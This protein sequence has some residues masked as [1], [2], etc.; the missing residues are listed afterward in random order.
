VIY[1][2]GVCTPEE[3]K[4]CKAEIGDEKYGLWA[5]EKCEKRKAGSIDPWT[6]HLLRLRRLQKAGYPFR[7]ADLSYDEWRG[8]GTLNLMMETI[9]P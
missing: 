2:L 4:K 6:E 9:R 5:C 8:L 7:K 1:G 3:E